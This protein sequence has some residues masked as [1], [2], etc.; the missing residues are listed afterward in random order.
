MLVD[1][2]KFVA[3]QIVEYI[4]LLGIRQASEIIARVAPHCSIQ[5]M[6]GLNDV[7]CIL[8]EYNEENAVMQICTALQENAHG[9]FA[10][11]VLREYIRT[12]RDI[13][14]KYFDVRE[15]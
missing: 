11:T 7:W 8:Q 5:N 6:L 14:L 15:F 13:E 2:C 1:C 10:E 4:E 3:I 9:C 12:D